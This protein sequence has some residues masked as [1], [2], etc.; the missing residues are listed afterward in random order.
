M[1]SC[2]HQPTLPIFVKFGD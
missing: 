2:Q 1:I